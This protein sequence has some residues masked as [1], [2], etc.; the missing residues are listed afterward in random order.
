MGI[1]RGILDFDDAPEDWSESGFEELE[2]FVLVVVCEEGDGGGGEVVEG[3]V[4]DG[5]EVDEWVD[6][7]LKLVTG[8]EVAR[9]MGEVAWGGSEEM[10]VAGEVSTD[11]DLV[12]VGLRG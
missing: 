4:S 2:D 9:G 11:L 10:G 8:L 7:V 12:V 6:G 5:L 1:G 3:V